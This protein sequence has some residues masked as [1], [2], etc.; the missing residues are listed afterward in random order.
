MELLQLRARILEEEGK[1]EEA[2][3]DVLRV[4]LGKP[5]TVSWAYRET[6]EL[7]AQGL[8]LETARRRIDEM[9]RQN[10]EVV[11]LV[12]LDGVVTVLEGDEEKALRTLS[13]ADKGRAADGG[14]LLIFAREMQSMGREN[15]A[16]EAYLAAV[17]QVERPGDR[18]DVLFSVADIQERQGKYEDALASLG[19]IAS[20]REGTSAAGRARLWSAEIHQKYLNDPQ[21]ALVVYEQIKDD[22]VLGHHRPDMLL[23]MADCYTLLGRFDEAATA[24]AEVEPEAFDPEQA[25]LAAKRMADVALYSGDVDKALELYQDMAERY[26]RSL[27]ADDAADRYILLNRQKMVGSVHSLVVYGQME[28]AQLAG[29]SARVETAAGELIRDFGTSEVAAEAWLA[30]AGIAETAGNYSEALARLQ[31]LVDAFP[32]DRRASYALM[33]EG[34]LLEGPLDRPQEA[35]MRYETVLTNYP[36]SVHAGDARRRVESLRRDLK[37]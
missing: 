11:S 12:V 19:R 20:E 33:E 2:F 31:S 18:A 27:Y 28:W 26:P 34:R 37:S 15:V 24:Y 23:Q 21:G 30:L 36:D 35:L 29:D 10:P 16:L 5:E 13:E 22:P 3:E 4:A 7:Q 17:D 9:R 32:S 1:P 8:S 25:E 6:V 14:A